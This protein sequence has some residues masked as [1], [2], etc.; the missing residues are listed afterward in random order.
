MFFFTNN[1]LHKKFSN[2]NFKANPPVVLPI[3][4]SNN[5]SLIPR[6]V[7]LKINNCFLTQTPLVLKNGLSISFIGCATL[8]DATI[9]YG[10]ILSRLRAQKKKITIAGKTYS[11]LNNNSYALAVHTAFTDHYETYC[12]INDV[13]GSYVIG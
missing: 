13:T 3:T 1:S 4:T 10:Q 6:N 7:A 5:G 2:Q 12:T 11:A 8:Q 9:K